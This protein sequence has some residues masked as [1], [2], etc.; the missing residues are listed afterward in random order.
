MRNMCNL[1]PYEFQKY[2][3]HHA[4]IILCAPHNLELLLLVQDI[5]GNKSIVYQSAGVVE[6]GTTFVFENSLSLGADQASKIEEETSS[7]EL[8]QVHPLES[9]KLANIRQTLNYYLLSP[10]LD[11]NADTFLFS[12]SEESLRPHLMSIFSR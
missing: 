6:A 10:N 11:A 7:G 2:V 12:S 1:S 9:L 8:V 4:I 5:G 3:T